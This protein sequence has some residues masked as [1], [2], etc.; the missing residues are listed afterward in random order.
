M[1][2]PVYNLTLF[3]FPFLAGLCVYTSFLG[4][5]RAEDFFTSQPLVV[6]WVLS[7]ILA[8]ISLFKFIKLRKAHLLLI[9]V[10]T[11]LIIFGSMVA[12]EKGHELVAHITKKVKP[13]QGQM[14]IYVGQS[15]NQLY[16]R[17]K[18]M[19]YKLPFEIHLKDFE[20]ENYPSCN[21]QVKDYISKVEII[22]DGR[23][24]K[25]ADIEVNHP[26]HYADFHF[27]QHSY[28]DKQRKYTVFNVVSD[29]GLYIV[30]TGFGAMFLGIVWYFWFYELRKS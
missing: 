16:D 12:S 11:I 1:K 29:N 23:V 20:I 22:K 30:F 9:H 17:S 14:V 10:G 28:D 6:F 25:K 4:A 18:N 19:S 15:S 24:V 3:L 5:E 7:I 8:T 2:K 21:K 27:Y 26:L 13:V